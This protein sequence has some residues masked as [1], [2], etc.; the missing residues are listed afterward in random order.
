MTDQPAFMAMVDNQK[1]NYKA[2]TTIL[3]FGKEDVRAL[4]NKWCST[5]TQGLIPELLKKKW[6]K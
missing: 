1:K 6:K 3:D 4:I 2:E 5:H